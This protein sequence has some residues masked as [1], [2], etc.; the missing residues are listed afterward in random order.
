MTEQ[1]YR[2]NPAISRSELWRL[3][4][5]PEKFRWSKDH[6][7]EPTPALIFGQLV[8]KLVLEPDSFGEA[9]AVSPV[10]DRRSCQAQ[11]RVCGRAGRKSAPG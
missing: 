6:P 3:R 4:E 2:Q 7:D 8:H 1:K 5:S 9:F 10:G 11:G